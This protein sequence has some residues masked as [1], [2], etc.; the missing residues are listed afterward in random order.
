MLWVRYTLCFG[1]RC[2]GDEYNCLFC[3]DTEYGNK[4]IVC[5]VIHRRKSVISCVITEY[6]NKN[7]VCFVIHRIKLVILEDITDSGE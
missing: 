2:F 5:F 4:N 7:I 1:Q 3:N 6:G